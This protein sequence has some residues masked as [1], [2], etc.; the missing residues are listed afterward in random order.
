MQ[1]FPATGR[2]AVVIALVVFLS[3][4]S[5]GLAPAGT[6]VDSR[7]ITVSVPD[8]GVRVV[9]LSPGATETLYRLG[10]R[11]E[12][13]GV[14]DFCNYPPDF[15]STKPKT[16]GY[17]TPNLEKIQSLSPHVVLLNTVVPMQIKNQ[18][19][20]LG[21][22]I[23]VTEPKSFQ[24]LLDMIQQFGR[25]FHREAQARALVMSMQEEA[26]TVEETIRSR[27]LYP[28][29]TF[30]E[31]YYN[32]FY[33]AGRQTLPGDIVSMA[34]GLVVPRDGENYPRM[35]EEVLLKLNPEAIILGHRVD[36]ESFIQIHANMLRVY[37][38]RNNKIFTPDPD[39]FLRPGPRV[40][41]ALKEIA[42]FLHPE[43][44]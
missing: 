35:N 40:V 33:A 14:S 29:K 11:D 16:G 38:I 17:S 30:I 1:R 7:G 19:E 34:G 4:V 8:E 39:E 31:I 32:P 12:I 25:L 13:V 3:A 27:S 6:A 21:V 37:A 24:E 23:F 18:F 36:R 2:G 42:R 41:E 10:L 28:V 44:F 43:A 20:M 9:S 22:P 26:G 5:A 15:V